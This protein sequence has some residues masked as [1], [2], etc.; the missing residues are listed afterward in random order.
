MGEVERIRALRADERL[1]G[2]LEAMRKSA[3]ASEQEAA[4]WKKR[5]EHL[6]YEVSNAIAEAGSFKLGQRQDW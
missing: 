3:D 4:L 2:E 5:Y 6:A 1:K